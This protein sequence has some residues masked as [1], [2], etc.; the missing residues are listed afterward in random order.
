METGE[1]EGEHVTPMKRCIFCCR[2]VKF[3]STDNQCIECLR[4]VCKYHM[5]DLE[6]GNKKCW[7]CT[8]PASPVNPPETVPATPLNPTRW[9]TISDTIL[10]CLMT[11]LFWI[12][13]SLVYLLMHH[14]LNYNVHKTVSVMHE[15]LWAFNKTMNLPTAEVDPHF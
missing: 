8:I 10:K 3:P 9:N 14:Y 4:H 13:I 2:G 12:I 1:S 6:R 7:T 11:A 5:F 15:I